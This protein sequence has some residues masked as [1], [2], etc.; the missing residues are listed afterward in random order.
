MKQSG[1]PQGPQ[2]LVLWAPVSSPCPRSRGPGGRLWPQQ[3]DLSNSPP[4]FILLS[5]LGDQIFL[6]QSR[7]E[8]GGLWLTGVQL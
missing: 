2:A 7:R 4:L 8:D 3:Q 5:C 1:P 6:G